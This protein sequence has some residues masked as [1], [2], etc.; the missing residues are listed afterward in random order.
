MGLQLLLSFL[1][2]TILAI[3]T[4]LAYNKRRFTRLEREHK[5]K[6]TLDSLLN[7]IKQDLVDM[8][9][10]DAIYGKSGEEWERMYRRQKRISK[11]MKDCVYGIEKDYR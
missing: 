10:D 3:V 9:K 2:L 4:I 7:E 6:M 1:T 11:A 8:L 5:E